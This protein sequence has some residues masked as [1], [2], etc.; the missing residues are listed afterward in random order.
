MSWTPD[1]ADFPPPP[2][3]YPQQQPAYTPP[4]PPAGPPGFPPPGS[5]PAGYPPQGYGQYPPQMYYPAYPGPMPPST[6]GLAIASV[7][8]AFIFPVAAIIL[9]HVALSQINASRGAQ[10]GRGLAIAGLI[11]GYTFT[12]LS[13]LVMMI[14]LIAAGT[15]PTP[16]GGFI[17]SAL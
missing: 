2:P 6:N 3:G 8:L 15:H 11:L 9:G 16:S 5:F 14:I 4:P 12:A 13:L 7:I 1:G 17:P 10:E